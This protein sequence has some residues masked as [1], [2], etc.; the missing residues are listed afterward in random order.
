MSNVRT[1]G[2]AN[3]DGELRSPEELAARL[4]SE[5]GAHLAIMD[6]RLDEALQAAGFDGAIDLRG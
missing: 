5:Y 3:L 4:E 1:T 6:Q 2:P